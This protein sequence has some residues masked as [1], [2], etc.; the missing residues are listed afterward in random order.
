MTILLDTGTVANPL[1]GQSVIGSV[2]YDNTPSER[3]VY[4]NNTE[5]LIYVRPNEMV[6]ITAYGLDDNK[7][8]IDKVLVSNSI[9]MTST[10]GCCPTIQS[11]ERMILN[12]VAIPQLT[13][14]AKIPYHVISIPGIYALRVSDPDGSVLITATGH[15]LQQHGPMTHSCCDTCQEVQ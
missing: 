15:P 2:T 9:P 11:A 12:R 13:L 14:C 7:A 1:A 3:V 8:F 10:G 6:V 4:P 5:Q